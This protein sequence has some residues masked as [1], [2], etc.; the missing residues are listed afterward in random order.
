LG[1]DATSCVTA[2]YYRSNSL[3]IYTLLSVIPYIE[4]Y[5]SGTLRIVCDNE[6][7]ERNSDMMDPTVA[8]TANFFGIVKAIRRLHY[9]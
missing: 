4:R 9:S 1:R 5:N 2:D 6:A 7:A 3:G 8:V